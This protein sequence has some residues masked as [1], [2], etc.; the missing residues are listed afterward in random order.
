[1]HLGQRT[2]FYRV[3][4]NECRLNKGAFAE[5]SKDFIN[6]F[7]FTK[8]L[9]YTLHLKVYGSNRADFIFILPCKIKAG[10]FLNGLKY[11]QTTVRCFERNRV[12]TILHLCTAVV[13]SLTNGFKKLLGE[14]HHPVIILVLHVEFHAGKLWIV[15]LV[16]TFVAEVLADFIDTFK[17]ADD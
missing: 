4:C 16:H 8:G 10:L 7:T 1:M 12:F 3:I 17:A 2:H 11:R 5:L 14:T 6:E 9:I 13:D 15:E